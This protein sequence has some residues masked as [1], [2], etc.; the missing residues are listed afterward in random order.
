M[1]FDS[2]KVKIILFAG[3]TLL[4]VMGTMITST[5]MKLWSMATEDNLKIA[6]AL[7]ET[8]ASETKGTLEVAMDSTRTVAHSLAGIR[9]K[10]APSREVINSLLTSVLYNNPGFLATFTLWEPDAFDGRDAEF[11]NAEGHDG[12]G[13]FLPYWTRGG[14]EPLADYNTSDYYQVPKTTKCEAI[15]N[16]YYYKVQGKEV[17]IT[18]LVAPIIRND[19][20]V[21][22]TGID[23]GLEFLQKQVDE[24]NILNGQGKLV[25]LANNGEI[26]A[27]TGSADLIG[28]KLEDVLPDTGK[29]TPRI[30]QGES[31]VKYIES[32]E[33]YFIFKPIHVGLSKTPW[34]VLIS[35]PNSLIKGAAKDAVMNQ[36]LISLGLLLGGLL[37]MWLVAMRIAKPLLLMV[38]GAKIL[39]A[40]NFNDR[41]QIPDTKEFSGELLE[42]HES[43]STMV[44]QLDTVLGEAKKN[45]ADAEEK[46]TLAEKAVREAEEAK[47]EGERAMQRGIVEAANRIQGIVERVSSAAEQ[48]ST[49]VDESN[50]GAVTQKERMTETATAMEEMNSTVM[51]VAKNASEAA[52]NAHDAKDRASEG[53]DIVSKVVNSISEINHRSGEMKVGLDELGAQAEGIGEIMNVISD[54]ADQTNLLALNAAIEAARAGEA[55]RGFAVVADEVRKLAEKTMNA[56][57]EVGEAISSI[58]TGTRT[59]MGNMDEVV[60]MV[61]QS[62][63]LAK[64]SGEALTAIVSISES[65]ADQVRAIATASEEQ[66]ATSEEITRGIDE[67]SQISMKTSASME[68]ATA[69]LNELA[70][71]ASELLKIVQEMQ[72]S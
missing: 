31:F 55:G 30:Q 40:S 28:K 4:V 67:V 65:T 23:I 25:I 26:A 62:T 58:Q 11:V 22:I 17:L 34:S 54:I 71:F 3:I 12:T 38:K 5:G 24:A 19:K 70:S 27:Y 69:A 42:L 63:D 50:Q 36:T 29:I 1:Q 14:V 68:Q 53:A 49:Q 47:A 13:R 72:A 6:E 33:K 16:P 66:T 21:G 51:E 15:V 7:A 43:L 60:K 37:V 8:Y 57:R 10:K 61:T 41:S 2:I 9:N 35:L 52:T 56:T 20:F 48:L 46:A 44:G 59:N 45:A 32:V 64:G 39:T 18:S